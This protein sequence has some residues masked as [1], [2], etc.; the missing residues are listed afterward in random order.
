MK[1]LSLRSYRN[2]D[3]YYEVDYLSLFQIRNN[4]H[5]IVV[6]EKFLM[7]HLVIDKLSDIAADFR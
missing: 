6:F 2:T 4:N 3:K 7:V 1:Y 5:S